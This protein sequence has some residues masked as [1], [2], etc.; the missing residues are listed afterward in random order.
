V[1]PT[2]PRSCFRVLGPFFFFR[3]HVF[4]CTPRPAYDFFFFL[5]KPREVPDGRRRDDF[6]LRFLHRRSLPICVY[7]VRF[8]PAPWFL[9]LSTLINRFSLFVGVSRSSWRTP[10]RLAARFNPKAHAFSSYGSI[11]RSPFGLGPPW[12]ISDP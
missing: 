2:P 6:S 1:L 11:V 8:P 9:P 4:P 3:F 5:C 10:I 12:Q 7:P